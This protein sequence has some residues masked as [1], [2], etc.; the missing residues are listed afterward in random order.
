VIDV[1]ISGKGTGQSKTTA[2]GQRVPNFGFVVFVDEKSVPVSNLFVF[3]KNL[4]SE[5]LFH[6]IFLRFV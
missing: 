5:T 2:T 6:F 1:R 3:I 4:G